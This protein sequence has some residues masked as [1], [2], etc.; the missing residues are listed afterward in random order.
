MATRFDAKSFS[1]QRL[2][3]ACTKFFPE[4]SFNINSSRKGF[5]LSEKTISLIKAAEEVVE[6][7][8]VTGEILPTSTADIF[9]YGLV[10][11]DVFENLSQFQ[12][13]TQLKTRSRRGYR[14]ELEVIDYNAKK[15]ELEFKKSPNPS[16]KTQKDEKLLQNLKKEFLSVLNEDDI[17]RLLQHTIQK[18]KI[19]VQE[20]SD[21]K[22][23]LQSLIR[24]LSSL[25]ET[26]SRNSALTSDLDTIQ[27]QKEAVS[28][29]LAELD[30]KLPSINTQIEEIREKH[31]FPQILSEKEKLLSDSELS[32]FLKIIT[33]SLDRYIRMIERKENRSIDDRDKLLG[34]I[35]DPTRYEGFDEDL[36]KRI[37]FIIQTHGLE[38]LSNKSWFE[39][40]DSSSLRSFITEKRVLGKFAKIRNLEINLNLIEEELK[41]VPQYIEAHAV[42]R[43]FNEKENL[44]PK[45][46]SRIPELEDEIQASTQEFASIKAKVLALLA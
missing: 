28:A 4:D 38:L 31:N 11:I 22:K 25:I 2:Q 41:G 24:L 32:L 17:D 8:K 10:C 33:T 1:K 18:E 16:V 13:V 45:L 39:F 46:K 12:T 27:S 21:G 37:V 30:E 35:V 15:I 26:K 7:A 29:R 23:F 5:R 40:E 42:L 6:E 43:E 19:F 34:M 20:S 3:N 9:R 44:L 14:K 36:W